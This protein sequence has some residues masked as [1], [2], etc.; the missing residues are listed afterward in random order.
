MNAA[1]HGRAPQDRGFALLIVLFVLVLLGF[2]ITQFLGAARTEL[3]ITGN[4]RGAAMA[5]AAADGGV[6]R[7][8]VDLADGTAI[9]PRRIGASAVVV[10]VRGIAG[11]INPNAAPPALLA[12]LLRVA[13]AGPAQAQ[14]I[15]D[16]IVAWRSPA[17]SPAAQ[18]ALDARYR[19][20]GHPSGPNGTGFT[21]VSDLTGVIGMTPRLYD[22][23]APH[24]S[25]F[26]PPLPDAASADP[27]VRAALRLAGPITLPGGAVE[28]P[29]I[30]EIAASA[31]GPGR[32]IARR[33]AVVRLS[34]S[35]IETPFRIL[36]W[37]DRQ[38]P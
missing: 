12:A 5:G 30:V 35:N 24:L 21:A 26:A 4:L 19:A 14:E 1:Q 8:I 29:R 15:A 32:A 10:S 2:L 25:L 23:I 18:A 37:R 31:T 27:I 20:T 34:P 22:A 13:G 9:A 33:C 36:S 3:T 16:A 17:A 28:G 11:R 7:A 6:S 38:C